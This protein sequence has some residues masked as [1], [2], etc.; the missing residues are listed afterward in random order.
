MVFFVAAAVVLQYFLLLLFLVYHLLTVLVVDLVERRALSVPM[1]LYV[2]L[3]ALTRRAC[4]LLVQVE[5]ATANSG[6]G[7]RLPKERRG[8]VNCT[9][10]ENLPSRLL[11]PV[12]GARDATAVLLRLRLS[13]PS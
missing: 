13:G 4:C 8:R 10:W 9:R 1:F 11:Q 2:L 3:V 6:A 12:H 5:R 7:R